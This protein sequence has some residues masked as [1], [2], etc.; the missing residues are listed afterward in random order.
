MIRALGIGGGSHP[1]R[2]VMIRKSPPG[3]GGEGSLRKKY[4]DSALKIRTKKSKEE[5]GAIK[6][7]VSEWNAAKLFPGTMKALPFTFVIC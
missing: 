3:G 5:N 2:A 6:G 4:S 7:Q 1:L